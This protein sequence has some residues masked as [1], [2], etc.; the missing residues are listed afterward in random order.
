MKRANF[1]IRTGLPCVALDSEP[2][3]SLHPKA[4]RHQRATHLPE[5]WAVAEVDLDYVRNKLGMAESMIAR[6]IEKFRNHYLAASGS[7]AIKRDWRRAF[8]NWC[9]RAV[10][11][12]LKD[13]KPK[14]TAVDATVAAL[15]NVRS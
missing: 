7:N 15:R 3:M 8:R 11:W 13:Q 2:E 1:C 5:D 10:E 9:I 4:S 12:N 6:E 14:L